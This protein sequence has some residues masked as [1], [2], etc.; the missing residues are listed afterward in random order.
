MPL[1]KLSCGCL[2][3]S[4]QHFFYPCPEHTTPRYFSKGV[5]R[6]SPWYIQNCCPACGRVNGHGNCCVNSWVETCLTCGL[7][8]CA[9]TLAHYYL[10]LET[11]LVCF[12]TVA[13]LSPRTNAKKNF[14]ATI[15]AHPERKAIS[16][17]VRPLLRRNRDG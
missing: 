12:S 17:R 5:R 9:G 1:N 2:Q 14:L 8:S 13:H 16:E 6:D 7:V 3:H 4:E 15:A 11:G 10:E